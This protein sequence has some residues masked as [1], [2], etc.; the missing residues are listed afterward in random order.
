MTSAPPTASPASREPLGP[1]ELLVGEG[2]L[3]LLHP[4]LRAA[5]HRQCSKRDV[6]ERFG[7][8]DRMRRRALRLVQVR[9]LPKCKGRLW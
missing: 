4:Q 5:R 1:I 6:V 2:N 3:A 7:M 8:A 9:R